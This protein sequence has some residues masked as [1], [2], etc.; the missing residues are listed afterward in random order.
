MIHILFIGDSIIADFNWN[1]RF[2]NYSTQEIGIPGATVKNIL[3]IIPSLSIE[4]E[5]DIMMLMIGTNNLYQGDFNFIE[6]LKTLV[7]QLNQKCPLAEILL[8]N[9]LPMKLNHLSPESILMVNK[10]IKELAIKTGCCLFDMHKQ[11]SSSP[12]ETIFL[13]DN[14]HLTKAGY[15]LWCKNLLEHIAFLIEDDE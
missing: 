14:V 12:S 2:P 5:P 7:Q 1:G 13:P 4:K 6:D 15:E 10:K 8:T 9:I 11:F 3:E